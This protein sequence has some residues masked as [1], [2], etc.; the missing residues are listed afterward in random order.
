MSHWQCC[1]CKAIFPSEKNVKLHINFHL[2]ADRDRDAALLIPAPRR[3][4]PASGTPGS[5]R[6]NRDGPG[7]AGG[8][9]PGTRIAAASQVPTGRRRTPSHWPSESV[10]GPGGRYCT[11]VLIEHGNVQER[12]D[13]GIMMPA[14]AAGPG[15]RSRARPGAAAAR[16]SGGGGTAAAAAPGGDS[17]SESGESGSDSDFDAAAAA[18]A[19]AGVEPELE[20]EDEGDLEPGEQY[21]LLSGTI[22]MFI[23]VTIPNNFMVITI[24]ILYK[25]L[26][27]IVLI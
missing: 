23:A 12:R 10:T 25:A 14:A 27:Y 6:R 2:R 26:F 16:A 13:I 5:S 21:C 17:D 15:P 19:G 11:M 4:G 24:T 22:F 1:G 8:P 7:P 20:A 3:R 9:G 18:A